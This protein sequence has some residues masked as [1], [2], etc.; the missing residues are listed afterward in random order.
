MEIQSNFGWVHAHVANEFFP[1]EI[2]TMWR[3]EERGATQAFWLPPHLDGWK[4][5]AQYMTIVP[6]IP[7]TVTSYRFRW[8]TQ[9]M[10]VC[11]PLGVPDQPYPEPTPNGPATWERLD[12]YRPVYYSIDA[13]SAEFVFYRFYALTECADIALGVYSTDWQ[14]PQWPALYMSRVEEWPEVETHEIS[15]S[16]KPMGGFSMMNV[17]SPGGLAHMYINPTIWEA[18]SG[19]FM[20]TATSFSTTGIFR[21]LAD[22]SPASLSN[23]LPGHAVLDCSGPDSIELHY[24][25]LPSQNFV[26]ILDTDLDPLAIAHPAHIFYPIPSINDTRITNH[27]L[28]H[29]RWNLH[30]EFLKD[31]QWPQTFDT[32]LV[33]PRKMTFAVYIG[34]SME[35][36]EDGHPGYVHKLL[37][38]Y[39]KA[40]IENCRVQF[41]GGYHALT[42]EPVTGEIPL[43]KRTVQCV[44]ED[45]AAVRAEATA[46]IEGL[47]ACTTFSE[48]QL[49]Y[50]QLQFLRYSDSWQGCAE[51]LEKF[52][53]VQEVERTYLQQNTCLVGRGD[54]QYDFDPCCSPRGTIQ[55]CCLNHDLSDTFDVLS[56][57][58][59]DS[60]DSQCGLTECAS[61]VISPYVSNFA[62][63]EDPETG[64]DAIWAKEAD[65]N[66]LLLK[67]QFIQTCRD[68]L[69]GADL[70]GKFCLS[71]SDCSYGTS[72]DDTGRCEHG[73]SEVIQCWSEQMSSDVGYALL[74][75][76]KIHSE[77]TPEVIVQAIRDNVLVQTVCSGAGSIRFMDH[78]H[79][80]EPTP[81]PACGSI[82]DG[83]IEPRCIERDGCVVPVECQVSLGSTRCNRKWQEEFAPVNGGTCVAER[84]C[85]W[86]PECTGTEAECEA[87]CDVGTFKCVVCEDGICYDTGITS[88]AECE[89]GVCNVNGVFTSSENCETTKGSCSI[90]SDT[91]ITS[92]SECEAQ[93]SCLGT[94]TSFASLADNTQHGYCFTPFRSWQSGEACYDSW[95]F[96]LP[97]YRYGCVCDI[98]N[99][100]CSDVN[101]TKAECDSKGFVWVSTPFDTEETCNNSVPARC[102]NKAGASNIQPTIGSYTTQEE[103]YC[104]ECYDREFAS[105]NTW[106]SGVWTPGHISTGKWVQSTFEPI[107]EL[108]EGIDYWK[109]ADDVDSAI[110]LRS[111]LSY[112][113]LASCRY[114]S[115][116]KALD[117]VV[118]DCSASAAGNC[119]TASTATTETAARLCPYQATN[120]TAASATLRIPSNALRPSGFCKNLEI[121]SIPWIRY[122]QEALQT[123]SSEIF[124]KRPANF[125]SIV[126]N[127]NNAIVGQII[128]NG[129][130]LSTS[131]ESLDFDNAFELCISQD[132]AIGVADEFSVFGIAVLKDDSIQIVASPARLEQELLCVDLTSLSDDTTGT[133]FAVKHISD[134]ADAQAISDET[135]IQAVVAS[136]LFFLLFVGAI[137]QMIHSVMWYKERPDLRSF[138]FNVKAVILG[139]V[140]AYALTRGVYFSLQTLG[141]NADYTLILFEIPTILFFVMYTCVIYLWLETIYRVKKMV[142][143]VSVILPYFIVVNIVI[144]RSAV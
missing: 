13:V 42:G 112:A 7:T 8:T 117:A 144:V 30:T 108:S 12:D 83:C 86:G 136:V 29:N 104:N 102:I 67:K 72:C 127:S 114:E 126:E 103:D 41:R 134:Y 142:D 60:I 48:V 94:E 62:V 118:C 81:T 105:M 91:P 33:N 16:Q 65:A 59:L 132:S 68:E 32:S 138:G 69:L 6:D 107:R 124:L 133:Y 50:M 66:S 100:E 92:K 90:D 79:F 17:C 44:A 123:A 52:Y 58:N 54:P 63:R 34:Y 14:A 139:I 98:V 19:S 141:A 27:L 84:K 119:Y 137:V 128:S 40:P 49:K 35:N 135:Y 143:E 80:G 78:W 21:Q 55:E 140:L 95:I 45:Y 38:K 31:L 99:P 2:D 36:K 9:R 47:K 1:T 70:G 131:S 85:N 87:A 20:L 120:I 93:G 11:Q 10:S 73:A 121:S 18:G 57:V 106:V 4:W 129:V 88:Q 97:L 101:T 82:D 76:W 5:G 89:A 15:V 113:S 56:S 61:K 46:L 51:E 130:V 125:F 37:R 74:D 111:S 53:V 96:Y 71:D 22:I 115:E 116:L 25:D 122:E 77:L 39:V 110:V 28:P 64:C 3:I 24:N 75:L 43:T 26:G 109:F 23:K